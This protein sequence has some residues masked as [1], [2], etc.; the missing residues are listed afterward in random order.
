MNRRLPLSLLV[1]AG[2]ALLPTGCRSVSVPPG[3][4]GTGIYMLNVPLPAD[5][6]VEFRLVETTANGEVIGIV[7]EQTLRNI[8]RP[9]IAFDLP[10]RPSEIKS[11]ANYAVTCEIKSNDTILFRTPQPFPVLTHGNGKTVEVLLETRR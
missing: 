11:K 3:V 4:R 1:L 5:A 8:R 6:I 2:L 7:S 10:Y 9:P